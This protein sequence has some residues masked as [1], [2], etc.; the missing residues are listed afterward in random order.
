MK[1]SEILELDY[2]YKENREEIQKKLKSMKG[3][4]KYSDEDVPM[5]KIER[6]VG[7]A[8]RKY[9]VYVRDISFACIKTNKENLYTV[10]IF[11]ESDLTMIGI[12]Y[13][14]ELYEL[15][16]KT[17]IY[18]YAMIKSEKVGKRDEM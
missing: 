18:I 6:F 5:N 2:R 1:V 8:C 14:C 3:F 17:A 12:V 4:D 11:K 16:A 7:T 9:D 15:M 10:H 13:G